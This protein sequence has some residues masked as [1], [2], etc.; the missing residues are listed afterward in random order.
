M[1]RCTDIRTSIIALCALLGAF[2]PNA[3]HAQQNENSEE[4]PWKNA[5]KMKKAGQDT[6]DGDVNLTAKNPKALLRELRKS[7]ESQS[8]GNLTKRIGILQEMIAVAPKDTADVAAELAKLK[9]LQSGALK[10]IADASAPGLELETSLKSISSYA[11]YYGSDPSLLIALL[12][13]PFAKR[14]DSKI[15][16]LARSGN[17]D[18]LVAID[19]ALSEPSLSRAF[20]ARYREAIDRAYA[21]VVRDRW[22]ESLQARTPIPGE[23]LLIGQ[24]LQLPEAKLRLALSYEGE[25]DQRLQDAIRR[26]FERR[27]GK[28]FELVDPQVDAAGSELALSVSAK[29][30]QQEVLAS[31]TI[32]NSTVPGR[33]TET[34]NPEFVDLVAKYEKAAKGYQTALDLYEAEHR[35]WIESMDNSDWD[36]AQNDLNSAKI[37]VQQTNPTLP[38]GQT[39][40]EY[41]A[42]VETRDTMQAVANS[43]SPVSY[44]EP[45]KP[46]PRHLKIL[47]DLYLIPPTLVSSTEETPYTYTERKLVY[48]FRDVAKLHMARPNGETLATS[49]DVE[50]A[51]ERNWIQNVGVEPGDPK[52]DAGSFSQQELNSSLDIFSLEFASMCAKEVNRLAAQASDRTLAQGIQGKSL[53]QVFLGLALRQTQESRADLSLDSPT[54][55]S[56]AQS[57]YSSEA[58]LFRRDCLILVLSNPAFSSLNIPREIAK[59]ISVE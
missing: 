58:A 46:Y 15:R 48:R 38:N 42:A 31:E 45:V 47:D 12:E 20:G 50:L 28:S 33:V 30:I 56:L 11:T 53:D 21:T 17:V 49:Y 10:A 5:H 7:Y 3:T 40:P 4:S 25:S 18:R 59:A 13:S 55:R 43:I 44:P 24:M 57:A 52:V 27:L 9:S 37:Q 23:Q 2:L 41:T 35:R 34:E 36:R 16:E 32:K 6:A 19:S 14:L 51:Q 26:S 54:L 22:M 29:P 1:N 8:E 39:N